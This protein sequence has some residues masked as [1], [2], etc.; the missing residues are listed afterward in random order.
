MIQWYCMS[1]F[2][3][4]NIRLPEEDYLRLKE[5]AAKKRKSLSAVIREKITKKKLTR[6]EYRKK[7]LSIKGNWFSYAEYKKNRADVKKRFRKYNW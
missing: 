7:L 1:N 3:V 2:V 4:T 5:E 6:E